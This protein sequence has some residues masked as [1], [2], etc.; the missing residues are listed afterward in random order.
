[1]NYECTLD[2]LGIQLCINASAFLS[3][4]KTTRATKWPPGAF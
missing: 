4:P 2:Q 3:T 1:M